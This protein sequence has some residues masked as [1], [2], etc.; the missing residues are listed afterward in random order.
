MVMGAVGGLGG[1]SGLPGPP[2]PPGPAGPP[3]PPGLDG[4]QGPP[5]PVG[6]SGIGVG[7]ILTYARYVLAPGLPWPVGQW[8]TIDF[9]VMEG[10]T[11]LSSVQTG[12]NWR[13]IAP[14]EIFVHLLC[15]M[16]I[17]R[18]PGDPLWQLR[19]MRSGGMEQS[20]LDVKGYTAQIG[21]IGRLGSL[22]TLHV[23][24]QP[25][26]GPPVL[27]NSGPPRSSIVLHGYRS[28]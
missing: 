28:P 27:F 14:S 9:N 20:I 1:G 13:F 12:P 23:E 19:V 3:G 21:W 22:E 7:G 5:G 24:I 26:V 11:D 16:Q 4:P 15:S 6:P 25:L 8:S 10:S 17:E 18:V 2:G